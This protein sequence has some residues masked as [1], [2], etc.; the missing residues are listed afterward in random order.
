MNKNRGCMQ[1]FRVYKRL[2]YKS[3]RLAA[4]N[5]IILQQQD[6]LGLLIYAFI[7]PFALSVQ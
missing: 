3:W 1:L 6:D 5:S 7:L 4:T 2:I